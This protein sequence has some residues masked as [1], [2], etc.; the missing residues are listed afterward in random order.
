MDE[1]MEKY[2]EESNSIGNNAK[3]ILNIASKKLIN[4][5]YE[6]FLQSMRLLHFNANISYE[7]YEA[8]I[9]N[10]IDICNTRFNGLVD[11]N[12]KENNKNVI[13]SNSLEKV[14]ENVAQTCYELRKMSMSFNETSCYED[15]SDNV[16][17]KIKELFMHK[18]QNLINNS[19][20]FCLILDDALYE[21]RR[22]SKAYLENLSKVGSQ[23]LIENINQFEK[24]T[25]PIFEEL[26]DEMVKSNNEFSS[27]MNKDDQVTWIEDDAFNH[28]KE[29]NETKCNKKYDK[30]GFLIDNNQIEV[31][32]KI[33]NNQVFNNESAFVDIDSKPKTL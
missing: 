28:T 16:V 27:K 17:S 32:K 9:Y 8:I 11:D 29:E 23:S 21:A 13:K 19:E 18:Y 30:Y 2:I 15:F 20:K 31:N 10:N 5:S 1:I 25:G 14:Q 24:A 33:V 26:T 7:E 4:T 3:T 6:E 12:V 22:I